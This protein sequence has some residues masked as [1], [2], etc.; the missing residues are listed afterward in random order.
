MSF[1]RALLAASTPCQH[2]TT[3][4]SNGDSSI[5]ILD[6]PF[7]SVDGQTGNLMFQ[8]G[9]LGGLHGKTRLLALNSHLHLLPH[10]DRV[11]VLHEGRLELLASPQ[12]LFSTHRNLYERV[13]GSLQGHQHESEEQSSNGEDTFLEEVKL[14][15]VREEITNDMSE[16]SCEELEAE[17][18]LVSINGKSGEEFD[19]EEL[20]ASPSSSSSSHEQN[21]KSSDK[22]DEGLISTETKDT[23]SVSIY[24][25]FAYF[26]AAFWTDDITPQLAKKLTVRSVVACISILLAFF[27][28]QLARV[29]CDVVLLQWVSEHEAEPD[30]GYYRLY[31]VCVAV[32]VLLTGLRSC[33]LSLYATAICKSIHNMLFRKILNA[34]VPDFFDVTMVSA[35]EAKVP[36]NI[37]ITIVQDVFIVVI[38]V[39]Y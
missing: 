1:C 32:F 37:P 23:H 16:R 20:D 17:L 7:S 19:V 28:A 14:E 34:P 12:E 5:V 2:G 29:L 38:V 22:K 24:T 15:E 31:L 18:K 6:D 36:C 27:M 26:G 9:V 11:A 3:P 35:T 25:Y 10:F 13:L 4:D 33:F 21:G 30:S 8:R 39:V